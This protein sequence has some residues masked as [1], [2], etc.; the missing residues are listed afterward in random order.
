[1]LSYR[2]ESSIE[3]PLDY[4]IPEV[5]LFDAITDQRKALVWLIE[6]LPKISDVK[7]ALERGQKLTDIQSPSG[8]IGVLRWVVGSCRAYLKETKAGEGVQRKVDKTTQTI[9]QFT[10]VVG[11]PQQESNF[12]EEVEKAQSR[13]PNCLQYPTI[14]AFHG[15]WTLGNSL[16]IGSGAERWHNILR[17]GL[18][19]VDVANARVRHPKIVKR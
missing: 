10:F 9:Q 5:V 4:G 15:E 11:S 1:M 17:T 8:S 12:E 16:M 6:A 18:D 19:Y 14:L 13:N 7:V 2:A 3:V